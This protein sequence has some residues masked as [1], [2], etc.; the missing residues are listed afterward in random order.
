MPELKIYQPTNIKG[1]PT[2]KG[3]DYISIPLTSSSIAAGQPIIQENKIEDY[4]LLHIRAAKKRKNLVASRVDGDSMEPM[5]HSGD[6]VVIDRDD[7]KMLKNRI[8]AIFYEE[9][10]TAKYVENQKNLLIL[11]PINPN[12]QVQIINLQEN[13]DPIVGRVIG[14]WKEL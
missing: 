12:S 14:A 7:K 8:F 4:V 1:A 3:E 6:I 13:P 11:R 9:G 2:V 10:L 5:L